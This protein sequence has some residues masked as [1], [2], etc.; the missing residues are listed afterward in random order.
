MSDEIITTPVVEETQK[1]ITPVTA[2]ESPV[3]TEEVTI[4]PEAA[5]VPAVEKPATPVVETI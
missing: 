3:E 1:E 5:A 2:S 4:V